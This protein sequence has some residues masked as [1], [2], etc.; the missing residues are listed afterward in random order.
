MTREAVDTR[1]IADEATFARMQAVSRFGAGL[2]VALSAIVLVGWIFDIP[3]LTSIIPGFARMSVPTAACFILSGVSLVLLTQWRGRLLAVQK[4]TAAIV[5]LI[6]AYA[7]GF[8]A[9]NSQLSF[10]HADPASGY[11]LGHA[12]GRMAPATVMSFVLIAGALLLGRSAPAGRAFAILSAIGLI[13]SG[14]DLVGYSYQVEALYKVMPFSAMSLPT[15][16]AFVLL[17]CSALLARP[18]DGWTA[19]ITAQDSGGFAARRL[20]PAVIVIPLVLAWIM[21]QANQNA[22]FDAPF[23]FA[24]L[25]VATI[26]LLEI[27]VVRSSSWLADRDKDLR[28][29]IALRRQAQDTLQMQLARLSLHNQITRAIASRMDLQSI[30]QI[31]VRS[32]EEQLPAD[33]ACFCRYDSA[34]NILTVGNIGIRSRP[35]ANA[36]AMTENAIVPVDQNGLRRC[37]QGHLVYEDDIHESALQFRRRLAGAGLRALVISPLIVEQ[38]VFG[39]LIIARR[40]AGSFTSSDCEFMTQLSAHIALAVH[41]VELHNSLRQAYDDLR[42]S[43]QS[44]MQQER[45]RVIGQMASGIA[46][47]INNAV[48]PVGLYTETLLASEPNL[49]ARVRDYLELTKRAVNDIAATIARLREFYR[50]P[51][52]EAALAP[53]DL[54]ELAMQ[55]IDFTRARWSDMPRQ[56]GVAVEVHA[57]LQPDLPRAMGIDNEIREALTNLIF[58]AVDAMPDGGV[59]TVRT[60]L[61]ENAGTRGVL[62]EVADTGIGMDEETKRRCLEPFFTT[63]GERGTGL[64]LAMVHGTFQRHGADIEIDSAPGKGTV[65]RI[66]FAEA[67]AS[68]AEAAP[69]PEPAPS[70]PMRILLVDDDPLVLDS[71]RVV[72]ELDNHAVTLADGGEAGIAAFKNAHTR[73]APFDVVFTD[74]GMPNVDGRQ[75]AQAIKA[76]SPT[77]PIVLLTGWGQRQG[78]WGTDHDP[79]YTL[80]KPPQLSDLRK[81]LASCAARIRPGRPA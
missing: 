66:T 23:G 60:A 72:L 39:L 3:A 19:R 2:V 42:L 27:I 62:L 49:S 77:T 21:T 16:L 63:K 54:N 47:D 13:L 28:S 22:I 73:G 45:L 37:V 36:L 46:H 44:A 80:G 1:P 55:A 58:N 75:V 52:S 41:Q 68:A 53:V 15:A 50:S 24:I 59:V 51:N 4:I 12:M 34:E 32:L 61:R 30:F 14:L 20:L 76:L 64:G 18:Y 9:V 78:K 5:L 10:T 43:Q 25:A 65:F 69:P 57:E 79:D 67:P 8:Y 48:S 74:L 56:R 7:I 31:V 11:I 40:D 6:C 70:T 38:T 35:L 71:M 33:F 29:E 81:T 26:T 17:F